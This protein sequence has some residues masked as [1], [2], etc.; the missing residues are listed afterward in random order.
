MLGKASLF[1]AFRK[2]LRL[3][4]KMTDDNTTDFPP[5]PL[6]V[7]H[8]EHFLTCVYC[9]LSTARERKDKNLVKSIF[10][11][12]EGSGPRHEYFVVKVRNHNKGYTHLK[13]ERTRDHNPS[14]S[15][16][17]LLSAPNQSEPESG[18]DVN[19][20][21][22]EPRKPQSSVQKITLSPSPSSP[23]L[24]KSKSYFGAYPAVDNIEPFD[25]LDQLKED[26]VY[27]EVLGDDLKFTLYELSMVAKVV[28]D[29]R[30]KYHLQ[31]AQCYWFV[32]T[33]LQVVN[34]ACG[35]VLGKNVPKNSLGTCLGVTPLGT[36]TIMECAI[37]AFSN[38]QSLKSTNDR[39][40]IELIL[41]SIQV[42]IIFCLLD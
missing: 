12:K 26:M 39:K 29:V 9:A 17:S 16:S 7:S 36:T 11:C 19:A 8:Y 5:G 38:F 35:E 30:S 31:S 18:P 37:E 27:E 42:L 14:S 2:L 40:A 15:S 20:A 33:V 3:F 6:E 10:V 41:Y 28:H 13:L 21:A 24:R 1:S 32:A 22:V 34:L 23:S 25:D 4:T